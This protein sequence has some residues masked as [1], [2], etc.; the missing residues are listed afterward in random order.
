LHNHPKK[1]IIIHCKISII[2]PEKELLKHSFQRCPLQSLLESI[3]NSMMTSEQC[4]RD[5]SLNL[6]VFGRT[7]SD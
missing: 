3:V 5:S 2:R 1:I 4:I 7:L 6:L